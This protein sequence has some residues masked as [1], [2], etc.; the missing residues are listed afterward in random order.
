M[1]EDQILHEIEQNQDEYISF[2]QELIRAESYNPPGNEKNVALIIDKYLKKVNIKSEIFP[3]GDN[4]ANLIA[5]LN[6]NFEGKNLLYNGHMDVV[7]PGNEEEWKY[8]PLSAT[9]KRKKYLYGRGATDMKGGLAA[10][11]ISLKIL[12]KLNINYSGN[13]ILNAVADEE[14]GGRVG[15]QWCLEHKLKSK[16]VHFTIIGEPTGLDPLPK[17]LIL[18]EKGRIAIKIIT[19]GISGH[20]SLPAI[21]KNAIYM[22]NEIIQNLDE[23]DEIIPNIEPPLTQEELKELISMAFPNKEIFEKILS[24]QPILQNL[25]KANCQFTKNVTMIKGGIKSNVIPDRCEAVIDFRL[26]PGQNAETVIN[27]LKKLINKLGYQVKDKPTGLPKEIFVYL[28]IEEA[29]EASFY[30]DWKNSLFLK[31]LYSIV[32][33]VYQKKPFY[34]IMPASADAKFYRNTNYCR[35]TILFGPGNGQLAH[36]INEYIDINDFINAIKVYTLFAYNF[37]KN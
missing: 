17:G 27:G 33:K 34:F 9:I 35:P 2:F 12:K 14:I 21:G 3:F 29:G 22:M 24:E 6:D 31:D 15:T 7:P 4:R 20:A 25:I 26:L 23:L 30:S 32:E 36:A 16:K 11:V 28:E 1:S 5:Y 8:S 19:N 37:L 18:G 13:L 10:M